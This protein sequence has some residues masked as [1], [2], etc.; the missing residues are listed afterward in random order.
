M[1][2]EQDDSDVVNDFDNSPDGEL[3]QMTQEENLGD[4][5]FDYHQ[6]FAPDIQQK[7]SIIKFYRWIVNLLRPLKVVRVANFTFKEKKNA[8]LFLDYAAYNRVWD[9]HKVAAYLDSRSMIEASA[10]MGY[11][12]FVVTSIMTQRRIVSRQ[13][14]KG[15]SMAKGWNQP[16]QQ[17]GQA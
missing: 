12:G 1:S 16:K 2:E 10:S 7:D 15:N 5:D 11:K 14:E 17:G 13:T 3:K 9:N 6:G 4:D 8:K